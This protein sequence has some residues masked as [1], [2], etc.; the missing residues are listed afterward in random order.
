MLA[1]YKKQARLEASR[2]FSHPLVQ[3]HHFRKA[4]AHYADQIGVTFKA[5]LWGWG[6]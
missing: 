5:L 2:L 3:H 6:Y 1:V 4:P